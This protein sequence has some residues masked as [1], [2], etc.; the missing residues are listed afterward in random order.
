MNKILSQDIEKIKDLI[1]KK[2]KPEKI[3]LFGSSCWGKPKEINDIDLFVIKKSPKKRIERAKDIYHLFWDIDY[4]YPV[5][6]IVY[7][8][9]EVEKR[10]SL[11]DF[12][13]NRILKDGKVLYEKS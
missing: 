9:K 1:A 3:I 11:G 6:V 8:P 2:Y 4:Q 13:I 10:K 7:T 5:D 12:F